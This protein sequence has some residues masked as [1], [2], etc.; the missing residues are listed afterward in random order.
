MTTRKC[1]SWI[2]FPLTMWYAIAIFFRNLAFATGIFKQETAHITTI[3]VGNLTTGGSGK[4]PH[5]AYLLEL[6]GK[7]YNTALLSRG[8]RRKTKGYVLATQENSKTH[9]IGDEPSMIK[10]RYPHVEV[11]VC[12][13]RVQGIQ[14]LTQKHRNLNLIVMDDVYQHRYIKPT[15]NILLTEYDKPYSNDHILPYGD[16]REF[17]SAHDRASIIIITKSP[18]R[19]NPIEK[20]NLISSLKIKPYQKVYFSYYEYGNPISLKGDTAIE[21][22]EINHAVVVTGIAHPT[23]LLEH[24]QGKGCPTTHI[25]YDDH[26]S[27]TIKDIKRI[28]QALGKCGEHSV[29]ITTEKDAVKMNEILTDETLSKL[30]IY[31]IPIKVKF[32]D[33]N[34][35]E[36][37]KCIRDLVHE[38]ISFLEKLKTS[39][40]LSYKF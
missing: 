13:K 29:I 14:K 34:E 10:K 15:I 5:V 8:Y 26:H 30:P 17:K 7:D 37:N 3:G 18:Q 6:L 39:S 11:A 1:I 31:Y 32:H 21:L 25:K 16:L 36:F 12:E 20:Y 38:N 4:T 35:H 23:P 9:H 27:Y 22:K 2:F 24:L 28:E 19:I 33:N 40:L